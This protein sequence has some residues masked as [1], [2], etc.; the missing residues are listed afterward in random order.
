M[1]GFPKSYSTLQ[2]TLF[3]QRATL[4]MNNELHKAEKELATGR[5][6]DTFA[7][8]GARASEAMDLRSR[9][10]DAEG[11]IESNKFLENKLGLMSSTLGFVRE[12]TQD[13]LESAIT[14]RDA[15]TESAKFLQQTAKAAFDT[16]A[17]YLNTEYRGEALFAGVDSDKS[18]VNAWTK[19][20][21]TTGLSPKDVLD[22]IAAG[23]PI[24]AADAAAKLAEINNVFDST[25][26]NPAHDYEE[27]FFNGT[28]LMN[29]ATANPRVTARISDDVTVTYGVQANDP[30]I[31]DVM[32]GLALLASVDASEISDPEAYTAWVGAAADALG[33]GLSGVLEMEASLGAMESQIATTIDRDQSRLDVLN[34]QLG[35]LESVDAYDAATRL[36]L[37]QTQIQA[38]Y[39]VTAR[40]SQMS[41][42]NFMP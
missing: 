39:A 9:V 24:D 26:T 35:N 21:G 34:T 15:T 41:F 28:P 19:A 29:G 33:S 6:A 7:A 31:R 13:I 23:G 8:L 42:L 2:G 32:K 27:T 22:T 20:D 12:S 17:G 14:N 1:I 3:R 36:N 4:M 18:A 16:I 38:S 30:A 25:A 5:H 11:Q 10:S 40:L 37:L